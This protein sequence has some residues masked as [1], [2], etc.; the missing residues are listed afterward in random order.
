MERQQIRQDQGQ[1]KVEGE[2]NLESSLKAAMKVEDKEEVNSDQK[3]KVMDVVC[4]NCGEVGHY[5][6]ACKR[7]RCCFICRQ[8]NHVVERCPKWSKNQQAAQF[9]GSANRGL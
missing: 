9:Y 6:T 4:F 2:Q 3:E 1:R 7:A 8:E 5:S